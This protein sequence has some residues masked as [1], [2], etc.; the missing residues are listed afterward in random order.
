MTPS[1]KIAK[2]QEI[3]CGTADLDLKEDS[4]GCFCISIFSHDTIFYFHFYC[5]MTRFI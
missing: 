2:I 1:I 4:G 5:L 3:S